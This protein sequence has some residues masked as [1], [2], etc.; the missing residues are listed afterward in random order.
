M[1]NMNLTPT[2]RQVNRVTSIVDIRGEMTAQ[3]ENVLIEAYDQARGAGARAIILNFSAMEHVD[4]SGIG[5][6][7]KLLVRARRRGLRLA[8][9]G[10]NECYRQSFE[11]TRLDEAIGLYASEAEAIA[12]LSSR[13]VAVLPKKKQPAAVAPC[14]SA[15]APSVSHLEVGDIPAGAVNLNVQG[16]KLSGLVGGFG[17]MWQKTYEIRLTGVDISPQQV[18]HAWKEDFASFWPKGNRFYGRPSGIVPGDVGVLNLS[19]PGGLNAPGGLPLIATGLMVIYADDETFSFMSSEGHMNAGMVTFSASV[20]S[21]TVV[22]VQ[23]IIRPSDP[24]Y[25]LVFRLGLGHKMGDEFWEDILRNLARHFGANSE[26]TVT[27]VCLDPRLQW[28]EAKNIW[29]NAA[30]RTALY[31]LGAPFRW[32]RGL[33]QKP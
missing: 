2:V 30:I 14:P 28:A 18:M 11:L 32:A 12:A 15:W 23:A 21:S 5:L 1:A 33:G 16:R 9:Y 31:I 26:P 6:L 8:G 20:E 13:K 25:E 4:S 27:A 10:L 19:G 22:R 17:Q 29:Q 3:S 7:P 24:F